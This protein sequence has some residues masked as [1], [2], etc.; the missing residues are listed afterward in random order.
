MSDDE[1]HRMSRTAFRPYRPSSEEVS[2]PPPHPLP[3]RRRITCAVEGGSDAEEAG[4]CWGRALCLTQRE[5]VAVA[6][7]SAASVD[8]AAASRQRQEGPALAHTGLLQPHPI[9]H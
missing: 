4:G 6:N 2:P 9:Q 8:G 3:T 1:R 7:E 5:L